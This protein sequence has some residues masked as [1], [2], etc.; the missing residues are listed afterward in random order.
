VT[1]KIPPTYPLFL[2]TTFR[3]RRFPGLLTAVGWI[4]GL[5]YAGTWAGTRFGFFAQPWNLL[6]LVS[7]AVFAALFL[8]CFFRSLI[9]HFIAQSTAI[10]MEQ[11]LEMAKAV[12]KARGG[13]FDTACKH[14]I[15]VT[16]STDKPL[17]PADII[18]LAKR[19][20]QQNPDEPTA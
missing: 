7:F 1:E 3:S 4:T 11:Q 10:A 2:Q 12:Q 18:E 19:R 17:T 16:G 13:L 20:Q 8:W 14:E 15:T 9:D 5:T 6:F